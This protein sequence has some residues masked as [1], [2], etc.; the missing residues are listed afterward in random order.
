VIPSEAISGEAGVISDGS[1]VDRLVG[2]TGFNNCEDW[3][4]NDFGR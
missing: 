3:V 4:V 2:G 1:S